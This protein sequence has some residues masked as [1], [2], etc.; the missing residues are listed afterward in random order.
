MHVAWKAGQLLQK[1]SMQSTSGQWRMTHGRVHEAL[2]I[3]TTGRPSS[4]GRHVHAMK[5]SNGP[6]NPLVL[7]GLEGSC[8]RC[9][10]D[11]GPWTVR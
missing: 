1:A 10:G 3:T 8:L 6:G 5:W 2:P 9:D 4:P 11:G 7:G